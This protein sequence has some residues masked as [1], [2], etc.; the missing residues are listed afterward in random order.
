MTNSAHALQSRASGLRYG[1]V[2]SPRFPCGNPSTE[3]LCLRFQEGKQGLANELLADNM[4]FIRSYATKYHSIYK[5]IRLDADDYTQAASLAFLRACECFDFSRG[6]PFLAYAG[7]AIRNA[8][9]DEI[10]REYPDKKIVPYEEAVWLNDDEPT[11]ANYIRKDYAP[12]AWSSYTDNPEH[13]LIKKEQSEEIH[14]AMEKLPLRENTW[15]RHRF[16]FDDEPA[17]L[18]QAA[19]D[20]HLSVSRAERLEKMALQHVRRNLWE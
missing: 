19:Q 5:N 3:E 17:T 2:L 11:W 7:Q 1:S 20:F 8:I 9:I 12:D 18:T 13:I 15:V 6:T 14:T 16:G 10:R 4:A